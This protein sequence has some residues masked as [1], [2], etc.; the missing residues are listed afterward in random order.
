M[1]TKMPQI[2]EAELEVMKVLWEL[3]HATSSRIIERLTGSTDWKPKTIQTLITRLVAKQAVKAEPTG[4]KAFVY[5]PL[6]GEA[7]YR[8]F[9]SQ[10]FLHKVFGGS[11]NLML[12]T[13]MKEQ[14]MSRE[15]IDSLKKMLDEEG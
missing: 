3:E 12:A 11:L 6:V 7:E 8:A 15:E 13:F 2:S 10:S 14:T 4:G 9:A 1:M 5:Y